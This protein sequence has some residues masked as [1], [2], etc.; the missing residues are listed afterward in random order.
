MICVRRR[1][2]ISGSVCIFFFVYKWPLGA[3]EV[4]S[5]GKKTREN[6][7]RFLESGIRFLASTTISLPRYF[8][9]PR[10]AA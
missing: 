10:N 1:K 4:H 9:L 8:R 3:D 6:R 7:I 2:P 5:G